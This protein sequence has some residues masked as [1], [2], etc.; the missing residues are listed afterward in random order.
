MADSSLIQVDKLCDKL[1][2][3]NFLFTYFDK[4]LLNSWIC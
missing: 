4:N 3:K 2:S 1:F